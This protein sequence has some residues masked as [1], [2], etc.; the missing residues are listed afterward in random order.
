MRRAKGGATCIGYCA[1]VE[2]KLF[3]ARAAG[4]DAKIDRARLLPIQQ[5]IEAALASAEAEHSGLSR[6][7]NDVVARIAVT[8]GND[9]DEYISRDPR[10]NENQTLLDHQIIVENKRLGQLVE[11]ISHLEFLQTVFR[12]RFQDGDSADM[13]SSP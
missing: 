7:I 6:R 10:D 2:G 8:L 11:M 13:E 1:V 5:S 9:S 4:R 12:A 3:K